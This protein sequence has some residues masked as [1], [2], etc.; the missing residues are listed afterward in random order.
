MS[1][2]AALQCSIRPHCTCCAPC[3]PAG[4][5]YPAAPLPTLLNPRYVV[6]STP[7]ALV[8]AFLGTMRPADHLVN[9]HLRHAPALPKGGSV[10]MAAA[11]EGSAAGGGSPPAAHAGY[12]RRAAGIPAEQL[13]QLARVQGKRLVLAGGPGVGQARGVVCRLHTSGLSLPVPF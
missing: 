9:L 10:T 1:N 2:G 4:R 5:P 3:L 12:L 13:Y 6:A 8:V 11:A 7:D